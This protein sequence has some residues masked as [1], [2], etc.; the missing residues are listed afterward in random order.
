MT[1]VGHLS[2]WGKEAVKAATAI[3]VSKATESMAVSLF[4]VRINMMVEIQ[5]K[6]D[7]KDNA[8]LEQIE[9]LKDERAKKQSE[10][11]LK[12]CEKHGASLQDAFF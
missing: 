5:S 8:V 2:M 9:N 7:N 12:A 10:L 3:L 4:T 11:L 1:L 6:R